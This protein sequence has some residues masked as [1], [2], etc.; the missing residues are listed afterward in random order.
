MAVPRFSTFEEFWPYYLSEHWKPATRALEQLSA[1]VREPFRVLLGIARITD[2]SIDLNFEDGGAGEP[3]TAE[4]AGAAQVSV[5]RF[6]ER[7]D[8]TWTDFKRVTPHRDR[9]VEAG[10]IAR[11]R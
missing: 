1:N 9:L 5:S 6:G 11:D 7:V 4:P 2:G 3:R 10:K 8:F